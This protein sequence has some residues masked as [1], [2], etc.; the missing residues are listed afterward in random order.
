MVDHLLLEHRRA[1]RI[2]RIR[3]GTVELED[4]LLLVAGEAT[5]LFEQAALQLLVGN[6]HAG[7]LADFGEDQAQPHTALG[8]AAMVIAHE[9]RN[10]LG[11]IKT[12]TEV[13]RNRA[14]LGGTEAKMLGYVIDEVRRIETLMREFLDFAQ[15]RP[16]VRSPLPLHNVIERVAAIAAPELA[17]H[18][19]ELRIDDASKGAEVAG[20]A[21]QLHQACLNLVLNAM[22]AMPTGGTIFASLAV[23][24]DTVS[25]TI[26]DE[27]PGVPEA[28]RAE[29]FNPFFTTKAKGTGLGLAKVQSV[30]AAH[31]GTVTCESEP[32]RGAAFTLALPRADKGAST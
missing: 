11:I 18:G 1:Q 31:G 20:D 21:D 2:Q 8:Q 32:G 16:L 30:A 3:I 26:R 14:R 4:F 19:I 23:N 29:V 7:L 28:I 5:N 17:R 10:P 9:V 24:S 22:D 6:S 12:S 15:P 25:L 27:G 13:V